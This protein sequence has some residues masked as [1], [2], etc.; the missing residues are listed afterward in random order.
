MDAVGAQEL[1]KRLDEQE[2]WRAADAVRDGRQ[3]ATDPEATDLEEIGD[4]VRL[5][6]TRERR[7]ERL[8]EGPALVT[9]RLVKR[10]VDGC[11][12]TDYEVERT[13]RLVDWGSQ[14]DE[15]G[16]SQRP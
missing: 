3:P 5:Y 7:Q 10:L 6:S 9:R 1:R 13:E 2:N 11:W 14:L 8:E 15:E 16:R 12:Q 4:G